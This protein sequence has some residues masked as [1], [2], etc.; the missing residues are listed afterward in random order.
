MAFASP[1]GTTSRP[2]SRREFGTSLRLA[3]ANQGRAPA[4]RNASTRHTHRVRRRPL[5]SAS[6]SRLPTGETVTATRSVIDP[7]D[8][9]T[10]LNA[11]KATRPTGTGRSSNR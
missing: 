5:R 6:M 7:K 3:T 4:E 10:P 9:F 1:T 2:N 11:T 8:Q